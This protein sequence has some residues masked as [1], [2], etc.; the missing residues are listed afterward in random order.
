MFSFKCIY[1]FNTVCSLVLITSCNLYPRFL[2]S[3]HDSSVL[4][5]I[6]AF[7]AKSL[8]KSLLLGRFFSLSTNSYMCFLY[9]GSW[10]NF[11]SICFSYNYNLPIPSTITSMSLFS[12]VY[13]T[14]LTIL[15]THKHTHTYTHTH[16]HT[17]TRTNKF[18]W[19]CKYLR[20]FDCFSLNFFVLSSHI[21]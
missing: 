8:H 19:W 1:D 14:I 11:S 10:P 7:S 5:S 4:R 3:L 6:I 13:L 18:F 12:Y 16:T 2:L 9:T 17:H 15:Y 20:I 21:F